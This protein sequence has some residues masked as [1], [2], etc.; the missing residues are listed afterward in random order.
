MNDTRKQ[1]S[2]TEGDFATPGTWTT[3]K[4]V[5]YRSYWRWVIVLGCATLLCVP[6]CVLCAKLW[7]VPANTA[8][9]ARTPVLCNVTEVTGTDCWNSGVRGKQYTLRLVHEGTTELV[10]DS[11]CWKSPLPFYTVLSSVPCYR[12]PGRSS[13]SSSSSSTLTLERP[14][15]VALPTGIVLATA[16]V[17]LC[18]V[19]LLLVLLSVVPCACRMLPSYRAALRCTAGSAQ[20][21]LLGRRYG[22]I[23]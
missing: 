16:A 10:R 17:A 13:S 7:L 22:T 5:I 23:Q 2:T 19:P 21:P 18:C 3:R 15:T 12:G 6:G 14:R 4:L 8:D 11:V 1:T 20:K 9:R